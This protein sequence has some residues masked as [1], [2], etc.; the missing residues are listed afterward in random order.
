MKPL[1]ASSIS[2]PFYFLTPVLPGK[3]RL[4][5]ARLSMALGRGQGLRGLAGKS[6]SQ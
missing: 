1:V 5:E 6:I 2:P 4:T 3:E